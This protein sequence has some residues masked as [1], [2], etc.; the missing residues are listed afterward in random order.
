M[1][2]LDRYF[3]KQFSVYFMVA[4]IGFG[5]MAAV[6]ILFYL[7]ELAVAVKAPIF[8]TIRLLI[9]KLPAVMVIFFPMAVLFSIMLMLFRMAKDSEL[10][11]LR[12]SGV[13]Q[14]RM[15]SPLLFI[16]LVVSVLSFAVNDRVVPQA[17]KAFN[18]ALD[19]YFHKGSSIPLVQQIVFKSAD[20]FFYINTVRSDEKRL[21]RVLIFEPFSTYPK[22]TTAEE[23]QAQGRV[24]KLKNGWTYE[25]APEGNLT[26]SHH[27]KEATV[28]VENGL[29]EFYAPSESPKDM[30]SM[31]LR[32]KI[33]KI[34]MGKGDVRGLLVEYYMKFS[35]PIAC[36]IFAILGM[37]LSLT[38]VKTGRDLWGIIVAVV[39]SFASV[40]FYFFLVAFLRALAKDGELTPLLGT[41]LPNLIY[42]G[43]GGL[44]LAIRAYRE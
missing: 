21:E 8:L 20:R 22:I 34:Q 43:F 13:S 26:M 6:D 38:F 41:W 25:I 37:S 16:G 42:L 9:Y 5:L 1:A 35:L 39:L 28:Q 32:K 33:A 40:G 10:T 18:H 3:F 31:D 12:A 14:I 29:S 4:V 23:V 19:Y 36:L 30:S 24:W 44:L 27:Y 15:M 11:I 17:N 7:T 2:L